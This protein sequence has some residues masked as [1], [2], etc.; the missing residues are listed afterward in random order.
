MEVQPVQPSSGSSS[1]AYPRWVLLQQRI[2]AIG[3]E[4]S[5]SSLPSRPDARTMVTACTSTGVPFNFYLS[6]AEPPTE[7]DAICAKFPNTSDPF[8]TIIAAHRDS[9][10]IKVCIGDRSTMTTDIFVYN[11]GAAAA[12]PPRLPSLSLLRPC[13]LTFG[14]GWISKLYA[15]CGPQWAR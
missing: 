9:I 6:L 7:S 12:D 13:Y 14:N 2:N 5:L 15:A 8:C 10:L 11:A 3:D 4:S 1:A